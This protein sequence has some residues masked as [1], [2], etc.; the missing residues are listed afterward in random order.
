M[1]R[2]FAIAAV[3]GAFGAT[4]YFGGGKLEAWE[5]PE[6][7]AE[8]S[9]AA[10]PGSKK[11]KQ[12]R[13]A[14]VAMRA[15]PINTKPKRQA[16]P[17]KKASPHKPAWLIE[18]NALCRREKAKAE[19]LPP[20]LGPEE[21][22]PFLRRLIRM[23]SRTNRQILDLVQRGGNARAANQLGALFDQDEALL[24]SMLAAAE[25]GKYEH[26]GR[27]ARS[28]LAV[29]KSEN[30]LVIRLGATDCTLPPDEFGL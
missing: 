1:F 4:L 15:T 19:T 18:L 24:Q 14:P 8:A 29:A 10:M 3:V 25:K 2:L 17:T 26:L 30:R 21:I 11:A 28:T 20:P 22:P 13:H 6:P 7:P 16:Q 27:L 23:N 5:S 12:K 9:P